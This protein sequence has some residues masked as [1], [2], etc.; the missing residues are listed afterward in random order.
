M[1]VMRGRRTDGGEKNMM[2]V[3]M[4]GGLGNQIFQYMFFR[5]LEI[6]TG[7]T[8]VIDDGLFFGRHVP[9]NG[10]KLQVQ[11]E[12]RYNQETLSIA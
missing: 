5:W 8:C 7:Q 12:H 11:I 2:L 10:G 3:Y 4:N 1:A 6:T 9:H